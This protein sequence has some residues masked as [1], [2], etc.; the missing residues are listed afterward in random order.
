[1][2]V[3]N[4]VHDTGKLLDATETKDDAAIWLGALAKLF[5]HVPDV[6]FDQITKVFIVTKVASWSNSQ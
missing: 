1:M 4:P 2:T 5:H 6:L 3:L